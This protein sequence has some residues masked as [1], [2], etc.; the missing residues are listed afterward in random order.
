M[1]PEAAI[2]PRGNETVVFVTDN[3]VAREAKVRT[4]QRTG[5]LVEIVTGV[6]EGQGVV[7]A[8]NMRLSNG[9]PIEIVEAQGTSN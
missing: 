3:N 8:G 7:V 6:A 9:A 4:G 1:V 2:V 5:G